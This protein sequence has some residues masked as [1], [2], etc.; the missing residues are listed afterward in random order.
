MFQPPVLKLLFVEE[1]FEIDEEVEARTVSVADA[2][3]DCGAIAH[4]GSLGRVV[5]E[6]LHRLALVVRREADRIVVLDVRQTHIARAADEARDILEDHGP[7]VRALRGERGQ[8]PVH[9]E[10]V[11]EARQE[12]QLLLVVELEAV[13]AGPATVRAR[14]QEIALVLAVE[15][16]VGATGD[17]A[18]GRENK[19][20]DVL[21]E[22]GDGNQADALQVVLG[23]QVIVLGE[24]RQEVRVV[25]IDDLGID[26]DVKTGGQLIEVGA[27]DA[28]R[29]AGTED[30]SGACLVLK[31][32][33]GEGV[34]VAAGDFLQLLI[35]A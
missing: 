14:A 29:R 11:K 24:L 26:I 35:L 6:A 25:L 18:F 10:A 1:I 27:A 19:S 20:L 8:I 34:R 33:A 23:A 17:D 22:R 28:G 31:M 12:C 5:V 15:A 16:V 13:D 7:A 4:E 32:E 9:P 2:E 3:V 21:A 30:Q